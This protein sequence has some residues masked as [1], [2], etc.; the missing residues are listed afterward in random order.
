MFHDSY[1]AA[2]IVATFAL[3]RSPR[4]VKARFRRAIARKE[5]GCFKSALSGTVF[6]L[7]ITLHKF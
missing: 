7:I 4:F 6:S 5:Q 3:L 1:G 2:E